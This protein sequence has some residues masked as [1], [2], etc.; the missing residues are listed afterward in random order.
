MM[1][2][3]NFYQ[4]RGLHPSGCINSISKNGVMR[5]LPPD[6]AGHSWAAMNTLQ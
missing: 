5:Y 6:H 1:T 4:T 3:F 2:W